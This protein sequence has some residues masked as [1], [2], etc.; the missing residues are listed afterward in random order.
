MRISPS[1]PPNFLD[2]PYESDSELLSRLDLANRLTKLYET[3]DHGTVAI[4]HGRWGTGKTTF[5]RKWLAGIKA[6]GVGC[7]YF[8]A[9]QNDYI[10]DPFIALNAS[11]LQKLEKIRGKDDDK[12]RDFKRGAISVSKKMLVAAAKVGVKAGTLGAISWSDLNVSEEL[13]SAIAEESAGLAEQAVE[14]ALEEHSKA[15]ATFSAFR[16]AL[17]EVV[18]S[19]G[20]QDGDGHGKFVFVVDELDR[21][22]PDFALR[23]IETLKHFFDVE[24]LHFVLVANKDFL[25][26]SVSNRYGLNESSEEYLDKFFDFSILFEE[27]DAFRNSSSSVT[28]TRS[29]ISQLLGSR[30]SEARD[31]EEF[32]AQIAGAF[33]LTLRQIEKIAANAA[34]AH[35]S[36]GEREYRPAYLIAYLCFLKAMFPSLF[37]D[38]KQ[39]RFD[40]SQIKRTLE[41]GDWEENSIIDRVKLILE[42]YSS[43]NLEESDN[44]FQNFHD[45]YHRYNFRSRLDVLPYLANSVVDRF[46]RL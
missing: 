30:S 29:V 4:L 11:L 46:A 8:S 18:A 22:R 19:G 1:L 45:S 10:D 7:N 12:V 6:D 20:D 9:F 26:K 3:L 32:I 40:F 38:I 42:Y 13:S 14:A 39:R 34:L 33:N 37:V 44:R 24:G 16:N 23:L 27:G 35:A 21:C 36:F 17:A 2:K 28:Y 43:K 25:K 5:V 31:I 15:E 41:M